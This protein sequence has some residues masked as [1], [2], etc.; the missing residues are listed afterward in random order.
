VRERHQDILSASVGLGAATF[1]EC[2]T[3]RFQQFGPQA[4]VCHSHVDLIFQLFDIRNFPNRLLQLL[5]QLAP[6]VFGDDEILAGTLHI[7][8]RFFRCSGRILEIT[9]DGHL[10]FFTRIQEPQDDEKRHHR[11][12]EIRIGNPPRLATV[13]AM[14]TAFLDYDDG[15][16]RRRW[17]AAA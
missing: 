13:A 2:A 10:Y 9:A 6:V 8:P 16:F 4:F 14:A 15:R 1:K 5:L 12:H 7:A 17:S 11:R 3:R